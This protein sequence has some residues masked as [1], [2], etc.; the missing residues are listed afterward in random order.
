MGFRSRPGEL[1][2][3][4][5]TSWTTGGHRAQELQEE[6]GQS[7]QWERSFFEE[8][9]KAKQKALTVAGGEADHR[10]AKRSGWAESHALGQRSG[11][12]LPSEIVGTGGGIRT[13]L[14]FGDKESSWRCSCRG[15]GAGLGMPYLSHFLLQWVLDRIIYKYPSLGNSCTLMHINPNGSLTQDKKTWGPFPVPRG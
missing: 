4:T 1:C 5:L 2:S 6:V 12:T 13:K 15:A 3:P 11:C 10:Q 14:G 8:I 9:R 7:T